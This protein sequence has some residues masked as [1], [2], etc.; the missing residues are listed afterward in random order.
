MPQ[1][2]RAV[3]QL[4][5]AYDLAEGEGIM[6]CPICGEELYNTY[7]CANCDNEVEDLIQP[8]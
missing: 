1:M 7:Y 5:I 8:S 4:G 6:T 2:W 3:V